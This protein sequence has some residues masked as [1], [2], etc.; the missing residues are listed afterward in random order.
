[1]YSIILSVLGLGFIGYS[2]FK[3]NEKAFEEEKDILSVIILN[4]DNIELITACKEYKSIRDKFNNDLMKVM[5]NISEVELS[6]DIVQ[7]ILIRMNFY[8][9]ELNISMK[10]LDLVINNCFPK[11]AKYIL[12]GLKEEYV[13][14]YEKKN[15]ILPILE[16]HLNDKKWFYKFIESKN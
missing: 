16:P 12:K 2:I 4:S 1:M 9:K 7:P 5:N 15:E 8:D 14:L 10:R 13:S 6:D 3:N 11:D